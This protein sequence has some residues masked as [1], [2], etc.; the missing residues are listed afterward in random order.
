[1]ANTY[2]ITEAKCFQTITT[3]QRVNKCSVFPVKVV[4]MAVRLFF[5][6][7]TKGVGVETLTAELLIAHS[8][9][10]LYDAHEVQRLVC[11]Y[12]LRARFLSSS[13]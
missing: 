12:I 11:S 2:I 7:A 9:L 13:T 1:M 5:R 6:S 4:S 8:V 3:S 10:F